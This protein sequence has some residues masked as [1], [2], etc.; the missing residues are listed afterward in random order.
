MQCHALYITLGLNR[1]F[2]RF[3][4]KLVQKNMNLIKRPHLNKGWLQLYMSLS[5]MIGYIV[6]SQAI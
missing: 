6:M 5:G 2:T 1:G 3:S 4:E